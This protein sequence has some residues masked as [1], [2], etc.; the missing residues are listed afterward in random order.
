MSVLPAAP[1]ATRDV[2]DDPDRIPEGDVRVAFGS[3]SRGGWVWRTDGAK[4]RSEPSPTPVLVTE[5]MFSR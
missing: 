4:E 1:A 3:T 2:G 5:Q